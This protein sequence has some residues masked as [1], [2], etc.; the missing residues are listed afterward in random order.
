MNPTEIYDQTHKEW[1]EMGHMEPAAHHAAIE[2]VAK[3]AREGSYSQGVTAGKI[4]ALK[5]TPRERKAYG[6]WAA[7]NWK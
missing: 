4:E 7:A 2:A 3:H 1:M 5:Y 6:R